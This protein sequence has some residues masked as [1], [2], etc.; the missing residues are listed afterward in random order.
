MNDG[1]R[2]I[3]WFLLPCI[4][5]DHMNRPMSSINTTKNLIHNKNRD[6]QKHF[7]ICNLC[8]WCA[9]SILLQ[10]LFTSH[11]YVTKNRPISKCPMCDA[12]KINV[13]PILPRDLQV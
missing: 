5:G 13:I 7:L 2:R 6:K 10:S 9:S 3:Y 11:P 1:T 4:D 12:D 8:F